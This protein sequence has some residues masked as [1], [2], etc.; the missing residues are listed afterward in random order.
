MANIKEEQSKMHGDKLSQAV[1]A[2]H[3]DAVPRR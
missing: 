2:E 1:K 3:V